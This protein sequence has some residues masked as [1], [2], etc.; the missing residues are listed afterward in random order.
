[1]LWTKNA[2]YRTDSGFSPERR[3]LIG[4]LYKIMKNLIKFPTKRRTSIGN[5]AFG[6]AINKS[7][8]FSTAIYDNGVTYRSKIYIDVNKAKESD[9][10]LVIAYD[11]D[12]RIRFRAFLRQEDGSYEDHEY[13]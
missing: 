9:P 5:I 2:F 12:S 4:E 7:K 1:M 13:E 11:P 8:K 3:K 10:L 6:I